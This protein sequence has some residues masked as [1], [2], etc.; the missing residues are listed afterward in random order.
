MR[1]IATLIIGLFLQLSVFAQ[2]QQPTPKGLED[3]EKTMQEQMEQLSSIFGENMMFDTTLLKG[4]NLEGMNLEGFNLDQLQ[5]LE[6]LNPEELLEKFGGMGGN[7]FMIPENFDM[8]GM[9]KLLEGM[10]L[11]N[12][13]QLFG[14]MLGDMDGLFPKPDMQE[15]EQEQEKIIIG[16]DGKPVPQKN[17]RKKKVYKL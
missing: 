4:F 12:L 14:P 7:G 8:Q 6:N 1:L 5:D 10:D 11:G 13:E 3:L 16:E 17:K 9:M 2:N 15:Q